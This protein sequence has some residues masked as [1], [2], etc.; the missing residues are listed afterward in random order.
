MGRVIEHTTEGVRALPG[1]TSKSAEVK[2][3]ALDHGTASQAA[4]VKLLI[5]SGVNK[6]LLSEADWAKIKSKKGNPKLKLKKN[7]TN[8]TP[9]GTN[10]RLPIRGR[11]KCQLTAACG[12]QINTIVYVVAGEEQ[13]LLGL[14]D[15]EALGIININSDGQFTVRQLSTEPKARPT[16]E[17]IVSGSQTQAEIDR[18]MRKLMEQ[19]D[20][21]FQGLGNA[22]V[23][24]VHIEVDA[25]VKPVQQKQRP[26][27]L[28]YKQLFKQ[29]IEELQ[30]EGVVSEP[31]NSNSARGWISNVV[32]THKSWSDKKIRVNLDTRPMADAVKTSHFPIPT[33]QELRHN[34]L[35]SDRFSVVDLNHAFHQFE[36]DEAS[37]NLFVFYGP[38]GT[39]LRF[40]RLVMG[41]SS[42]SSECHE[43]IRQIVEGLEGVQQIKDDVVV[44]GKGTE[45][46][47]RLE[48]LFQRFK[49]HNITLRKEK[50][51]LGLPQVKWF[52][53]FY[54]KQGM[55]ADPAKVEMIRGWSRPADKS[56]VKSFLQTVQFCQ[57]F[58]RPDQTAGP[59]TYSDI[60]LPLRRLTVK[61]MKFKWTQECE[62]SFEE[63]KELLTSDRVLANYDPMKPTRIYV[64]DGP[65]GVAA[66]VAQSYEV[67]GIDHPVWRPVMHTS[68]AK[69]A[70]EMN[71]G[72]VDG[73]SLAVLTGIH[74]NKMYL[75]GT[76]FTVVVDHEPLVPMYSSHSKSLPFRVAKHKSKLR[77]FDFHLIY[78]PGLTTPAP[79]GSRHPPPARTYNSTERAEL[80]VEEEEDAEI[81]VNRIGEVIDAVTLP[82]LKHHTETDTTLQMLKKDIQA[83]RLRP[84]LITTGYKGC[85]NELSAKDG[86]ILRDSRLLIPPSLRPDVLGAAHEGHAARDSMTR[87]LRQTVWWPG[88]T[89][90]IREYTASCLGCAAAEN[91]NYPP[92]MIERE[93]PIGPWIDC[94]ADFKG[95]IAGKYYFHVLI[96]N[97]SRWPEVE[98]VSSTNFEQLRPA[99]DRSFSLLGIPSTITH[100]CGPPYQSSAWNNYAKEMGFEKRPCTPEHPEA[101]GIAERF[102][103]VLVK[104]VHAAIAEGKD[105]QVEVR[106]RLTLFGP[107]GGRIL[108]CRHIFLDFSKLRSSQGLKL[109]DF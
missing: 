65:A 102:M 36:M 26:I 54:S 78:E 69:T 101:N 32:I 2:I 59:R 10:I 50:C 99:L 100:D 55:S 109:G 8:F 95:P 46:D 90:D 58:M 93:T 63:L 75:Y 37:K 73:E 80:G 77:G 64:D 14:K 94:S 47:K 4:T 19:Y 82:I 74:S 83:G 56:E 86:V 18:N 79:Y 76:K 53:N 57:V 67:E 87:Q 85:F 34:F 20:S 104:T 27:A 40:N 38:D 15:G 9:F 6:T 49:G 68:R 44:H 25:S 43:R 108:P 28:Q 17:G 98:V 66:T 52:E 62:D 35:G 39:L 92:P 51:Q 72:K 1:H 91:R 70:A 30:R 88:I 48:A 106:R 41:T 96:D 29:H 97:Y 21:L 103:V 3:V 61:N 60:T 7:K 5:D 23:E 42:A 12:A 31:L 71:Y 22:T 13:S 89:R 33:P 84:E 45:H 105:P 16:A 11:T 81:I 24:P 107:G